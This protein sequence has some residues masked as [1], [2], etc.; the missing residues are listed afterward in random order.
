[1]LNT[2]ITPA[3]KWVGGKTQLLESIKKKIPSHY[4]NYFEPFVGGA[5]VLLGL[6][7]KQATINDINEQLINLYRQL[8]ISVE[9]VIKEVKKL[10]LAPCTK[11]RYYNI[12]ERYNKKIEA[13]VQDVESAAI[14]I[15]LN[16]HC[17][18]GLYRVNKK[19]LFNV[20]YNNRV[21]GKSIDENN[22]RAIGQYLK[23]EDINIICKDFEE[24]CADVKPGDFVY[25]DSPYVPESKTADFTDYSK[26][27]FSLED[28]K[29]LADLFR[30]LDKMGAKVMLSNNDVSLVRDFYAGYNIQS[31]DVKRMINRNANKRVGKEVLIT[32]Y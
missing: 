24:A 1:M 13:N 30:K 10:D 18:N 20:P 7:P 2:E 32:N 5:A 8:K 26:E 31:L 29:R 11:E 21:N 15:W 9:D 27:G 12:R 3:L 16:K 4:N 6:Q 17:F 19:G 23:N 14:M 28:H 25:F 22:I